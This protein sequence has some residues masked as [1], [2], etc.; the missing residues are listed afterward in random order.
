M[1]CKDD[2]DF[3][4]SE[5]EL[6]KSNCNTK[7]SENCTNRMEFVRSLILLMLIVINE[8]EQNTTE[9]VLWETE[10]VKQQHRQ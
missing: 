10:L 3:E 2:G 5:V 4:T 7:K 1:A 9:S 6:T 8:S